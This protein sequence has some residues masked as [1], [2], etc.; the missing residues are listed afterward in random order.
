MEIGIAQ[1]SLHNIDDTAAA[2]TIH[3]LSTSTTLIMDN[4]LDKD[5]QFISVS[6]VMGEPV[7]NGDLTGYRESKPVRA[8]KTRKSLQAE[9]GSKAKTIKQLYQ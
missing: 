8:R 5:L 3:K 7:G 4:N 2:I 9:A 1:E 6:S